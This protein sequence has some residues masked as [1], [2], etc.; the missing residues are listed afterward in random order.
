MFTALAHV[1]NLF[2]EKA[3][4]LYPCLSVKEKGNPSIPGL[5][6]FFDNFHTDLNQITL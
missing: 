5:P 6:F 3:C 1:K 4:C 2:V